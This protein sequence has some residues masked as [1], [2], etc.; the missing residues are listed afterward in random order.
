MLRVEEPTTTYVVDEVVEGARFTWSSGVPGARGR[1]VHAVRAVDHELS[2]VTLT[3]EQ[4][5]LAAPL[6]RLSIGLVRRYVATEA[7][8]LRRRCED[9]E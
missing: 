6:G 3:L 8:G 5:G 9:S 7:A 4:T 1:G 2:E